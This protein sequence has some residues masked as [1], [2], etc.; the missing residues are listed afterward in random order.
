MDLASL[1]LGMNDTKYLHCTQVVKSDLHVQHLTATVVMTPD[2]QVHEVTM[3]H[4][5]QSQGNLERVRYH[6][7]RLIVEKEGLYYIYAKTCFRYYNGI[8]T[9]QGVPV[10]MSNLE[11]MQY[12]SHEKH[13]SQKV[14][15]VGLM[16][17]GST[18]RWD[19][20]P[21]NMYCAQQGLAMTLKKGDSL[22]VQVSNIRFLDPD[23]QG[24]YFGVMMLSNC[25]V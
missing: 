21:N 23:T 18:V 22:Y 10:N 8:E 16:K 6:D 19:D 11:L 25:E 20:T 5:D 3:I 17:T 7:G 2:S 12:I 4:W 15:P 24:T 13:I 9:D 14:T 1:D